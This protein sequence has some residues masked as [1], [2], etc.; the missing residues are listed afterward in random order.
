MVNF[1]CTKNHRKSTRF[2]DKCNFKSKWLEHL[3]N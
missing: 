3:R 2:N 1:W